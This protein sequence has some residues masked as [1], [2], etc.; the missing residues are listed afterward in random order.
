MK[1]K[2]GL[3]QHLFHNVTSSFEPL[4]RVPLVEITGTNRVLIENHLGVSMYSI[5]EITVR[6]QNG[7]IC[8]CGDN[9][10]ILQLMKERVVITGQIHT[11]HLDRTE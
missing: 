4:H 3:L 6:V 7:F 5:N 11:I 10:L 2:E 8:V 1:Q 9:L